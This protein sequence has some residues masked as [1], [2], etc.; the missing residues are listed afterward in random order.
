MTSDSA[1]VTTLQLWP[2]LSSAVD[3]TAKPRPSATVGLLPT[4]GPPGTP[5]VSPVVLGAVALLWSIPQLAP[6]VIRSLW[7]QPGWGSHAVHG[8]FGSYRIE[9]WYWSR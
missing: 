5:M 3:M 8:F 4:P 2:A 6:W 9:I 7:F 1:S